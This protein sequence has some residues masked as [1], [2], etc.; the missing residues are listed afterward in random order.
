MIV[1]TTTRRLEMIHWLWL[2]VLAAIA[3]TVMQ[4]VVAGQARGFS[5]RGSSDRASSDR[6]QDIG[7]PIPMPNIDH[8]EWFQYPDRFPAPA[9]DRPS[10]PELL[11]YQRLGDDKNALKGWKRIELL[12]ESETWKQ[13]GIGVALFHLDRLD[14]AIERFET[15]LEEDEHNAVAEYFM[16]RVRQAQGRRV[17]FWYEPDP[18]TPFRLASVVEPRSTEP[19]DILRQDGEHRS[20]M[21]LPHFIDDAYDRLARRHFRRAIVLSPRCDLNQVIRVAV[22]KPPLI[23]LTSFTDADESITVGDLLDSLGER[24]Y[25]RKA[26]AELGVDRSGAR[27]GADSN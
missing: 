25:V 17:P 5:D 12:P 20:K 22:K 14:E 8:P 1:T 11:R 2:W 4:G 21:F 23:Q 3:I 7:R 6:G 19:T 24:D 10:L 18:D 16:G 26:K 15:A 27:P 13:V 9:N